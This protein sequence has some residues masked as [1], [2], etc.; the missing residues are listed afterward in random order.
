VISSSQR[1]LP[2]NTQHSQQTNIH[3]RGGIRTHSLSRRAT[4]DRPRTGVLFVT[5][6]IIKIMSSWIKPIVDFR[7]RLYLHLIPQPLQDAEWAMQG[8]FAVRRICLTSL[9]V[10][11]LKRHDAR[12][13][14][15]PSVSSVR[16]LFNAPKLRTRRADWLD[17]R[18]M[19]MQSGFVYAQA[20]NEKR[21]VG[22]GCDTRCNSGTLFCNSDEL[23]SGWVWRCWVWIIL[24]I[25]AHKYAQ[26]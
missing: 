24:Y 13:L 7:R 2:D 11:T 3:A 21:P 9:R 23:W 25:N 20:R 5:Y 10:T 4:A 26:I 1:S 15:G 6:V 8:A 17:S 19:R 12:H 18:C 14:R 22:T 16:A